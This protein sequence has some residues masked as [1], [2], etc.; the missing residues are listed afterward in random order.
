MPTYYIQYSE[1]AEERAVLSNLIASLEKMLSIVVFDAIG[2][3]LPVGDPAG[4]LIRSLARDVI[5]ERMSF[6]EVTSP[7]A[8]DADEIRQEEPGIVPVSATA[9]I[10]KVTKKERKCPQCGKVYISKSNRQQFCSQSCRI[11]RMENGSG[12]KKGKLLGDYADR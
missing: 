2:I 6:A 11:K 7:V 8:V 1:N 4:E 10:A 9:S 3:V 5:P 12:V